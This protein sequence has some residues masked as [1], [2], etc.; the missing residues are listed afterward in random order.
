MYRPGT[1][2]VCTYALLTETPG[3]CAVLHIYIT[4]ADI[5][6]QELEGGHLMQGTHSEEI[7]LSGVTKHP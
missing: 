4:D 2:F 5:S 7:W 6:E 3:M 1:V